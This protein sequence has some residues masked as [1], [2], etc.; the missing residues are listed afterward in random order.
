MPPFGGL[1]DILWNTQPL[2]IDHAKTVLSPCQALA[3]GN[4]KQFEGLFVQR[5]K[6]L[7]RLLVALIGGETVPL[8]RLFIIPWNAL[9][10]VVDAAEVV[11]SR[12]ESSFGGEAVPF[13]SL[14]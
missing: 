14:V 1:L 13:D 8:Q 2:G 3:G 11:L 9:A 4:S 10:L 5:R 6:D 12:C 7:A